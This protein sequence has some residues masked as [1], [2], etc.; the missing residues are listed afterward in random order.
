SAALPPWAKVSIPASTASGWAAATAY[1]WSPVVGLSSPGGLA[2]GVV[3]VSGPVAS[4]AAESSGVRAGSGAGALHEA[5]SRTV[6]RAGTA[7][8]AEALM[9]SFDSAR[10]ISQQSHLDHDQSA[11]GPSQPK[12]SRHCRPCWAPDRYGEGVPPPCPRTGTW[13]TVA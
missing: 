3:V 1:C 4:D 10:V 9:R 12:R 13:C 2:G 7:E 6:A 11:R 5:K 8:R